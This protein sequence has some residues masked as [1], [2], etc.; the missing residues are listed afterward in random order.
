MERKLTIRIPEIW[1]CEKEN[2]FKVSKQQ[3][4][5]ACS[6]PRVREEMSP[7]TLARKPKVIHCSPLSS[8]GGRLGKVN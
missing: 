1:V 7:T 6:D 5:N 8:D 2:C 4:C 3:I